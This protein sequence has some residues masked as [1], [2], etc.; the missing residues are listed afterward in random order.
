MDTL[1]V[2]PLGSFLYATSVGEFGFALGTW[3]G[4]N[5]FGVGF[6]YHERGAVFA[7]WILAVLGSAGEQASAQQRA[8]QTGQTQYYRQYSPDD[9]GRVGMTID[10][11]STQLGG[12]VSGV[13]FDLFGTAKFNEHSD[14]PWLMDFGMNLHLYDGPDEDIADPMNPGQMMTDNHETGG[15]GLLWGVLV[16]ATKWAQIELKWRP[17]IP[18]SSGAQKL[19]DSWFT[20]EAGAT[21]NVGN[22][23][24]G[25]ASYVYGQNGDTGLLFGIGGRL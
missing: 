20:F 25:R 7:K 18:A 23:V 9:F 3:P 14:T 15:L 13:N 6:H 16:P 21:L 2:P 24:Y 8:N 4:T 5:G 11:F 1:G 12:N 22:R 17:V 10:S 19:H